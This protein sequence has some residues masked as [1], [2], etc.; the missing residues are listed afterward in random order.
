MSG[1]IMRHCS[2]MCSGCLFPTGSA[3]IPAIQHYNHLLTD[4]WNVC[5]CVRERERTAKTGKSPN[6]ITIFMTF[7]TFLRYTKKPLTLLESSY[8]GAGL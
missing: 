4:Q 1:D 3:F 2:V 7:L 8:A 5:Q 6:F